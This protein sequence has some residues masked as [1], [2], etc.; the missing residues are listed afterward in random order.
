[1]AVLA[2]ATRAA[3][4][5]R[6]TTTWDAGLFAMGVRDY[7][8]VAGQPHPPGYPLTVLL[9][10][11]AHLVAQDEASA[12]V[13]VS[14]LASGAA[15]AILHRLGRGVAGSWAGLLAALTFVLSPLALFNGSVGMSYGLEA[16]TS[17]L[18]GAAAWSARASPTPRALALVGLAAAAAAG[19]RPSAVLFLAPLAAWAALAPRA[20]LPMRAWRLAWTGAIGAAALAVIVLPAYAAGGGVREVLAANQAQTRSVVLHDPV[21]TAG[22]GIVP[23]NLDHLASYAAG[24][25]RAVPFLAAALFVLAW[26]ARG[27]P[28]T[29]EAWRPAA[30]LAAW[31]LPAMLFY[32]FVYVGWPIFPSGYL[33]VVLPAAG[34]GVGALCAGLGAGAL[35]R[36]ATLAVGIVLLLAGGACMA[37]AWPA[38]TRPIRAAD[39]W[40]DSWDGFAEAF[41]ANETAVTTFGSWVPLKLRHPEHLLFVDV[42]YDGIDQRVHRTVLVSQ[43]GRDEPRYFDIVTAQRDDWPEHPIPDWVKRIVVHDG[44]PAAALVESRLVLLRPDVPLQSTTLPSG[45][46]VQWFVPEPG[47]TIEDYKP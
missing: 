10:K 2:V 21:W 4:R 1:M 30:F 37:A 7:D 23:T 26:A 22:W 29:R 47:S 31:S 42:L 41:P 20:P 12:M 28:R 46:V 17:A 38:A 44:H 13:W 25:L 16:A 15:A 11:A 19:V 34:V 5:A 6:T 39:A 9:G 36:P 14:V 24:E 43:G 27:Q 35:R 45:R 32:T 40:E 18:V 33:M 8:V 3:V